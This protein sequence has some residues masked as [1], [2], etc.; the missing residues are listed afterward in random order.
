ML[1][2]HLS[3]AQPPSF[4]FSSETAV[5]E[6]SH[7]RVRN[8]RR[9]WKG[10]NK[11]DF[12]EKI[13]A[14]P[15]GATGKVISKWERTL[16]PLFICK[17]TWGGIH[18]SWCVKYNILIYFVINCENG[19]LHFDALLFQWMPK[20]TEFPK[21]QQWENYILAKWECKTTL[22]SSNC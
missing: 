11:K 10:R 7:V 13:W 19:G 22:A 8:T 2:L 1:S 5:E 3:L 14:L 15:S 18:S 21:Q 16:F 9:R 12:G 17:S 20:Q 6:Q 4:F